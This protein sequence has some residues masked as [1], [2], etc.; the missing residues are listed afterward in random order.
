NGNQIKAAIGYENPK[1]TFVALQTVTGAANSESLTLSR[2]FTD[3]DK[4]KLTDGK[5]IIKV[6]AANTTTANSKYTVSWGENV[7]NDK[8]L[9]EIELAD[10]NNSGWVGVGDN[11]D[12][13]YINASNISANSSYTLTLDGI[14][15]NQIKAA[16]GYENP[17]GTFVALQTV[18]GAAK[19]RA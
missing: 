6:F 10:S 11:A 5:L 13:Y 8:L 15:G 4:A 3:A 17:K 18:T 7:E 19:V 9:G 2:Q 12:Y 16:I 1:G 14:N